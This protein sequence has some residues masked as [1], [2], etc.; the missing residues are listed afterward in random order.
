MAKKR[1]RRCTTLPRFLL[2]PHKHAT[3]LTRIDVTHRLGENPT[4]AG[5]VQRGV[6]PLAI[7]IGYRSTQHSC[8]SFLRATEVLICI[9]DPDHDRLGRRVGRL[10]GARH[11]DY[12]STTESELDAMIGDAQALRITNALTSHCAAAAISG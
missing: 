10:Q 5:K 3:P 6:L 11:Q 8:A 7:G 1:D 4:M 12:S 2:A 9:V